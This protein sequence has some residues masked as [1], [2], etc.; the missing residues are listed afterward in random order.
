MET[1]AGQKRS[2]CTWSLPGFHSCQT[3]SGLCS[4]NNRVP[5]APNFCLW[6]TGKTYF[7]YVNLS[8]GH[9]WFHGLEPLGSL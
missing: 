2:T 3:Q 9:P 1:F 5:Q 8:A 7:F 6:A 4:R